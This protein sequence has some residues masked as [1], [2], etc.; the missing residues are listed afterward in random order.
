MDEIQSEFFARE[1]IG[2]ARNDGPHRTAFSCFLTAPDPGAA[3][4]RTSKTLSK[5]PLS[6]WSKIR[7]DGS[8]RRRMSA[9][10]WLDRQARGL[11]E[12]R[13]SRA[14]GGDALNLP[15]RAAFRPWQKTPPVPI[16]SEWRDGHICRALSCPAPGP[17]R[18]AP[19]A[20]RSATTARAQPP[21]PLR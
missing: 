14:N 4:E 2:A 8:G 16:A 7:S 17:V 21:S 20:W 19:F 5:R 15:T 11:E 1:K 9:S 3:D 10:N 13:C 18:L 12:T 6:Q